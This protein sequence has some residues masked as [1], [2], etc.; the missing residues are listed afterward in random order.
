MICQ[1]RKNHWELNNL[2][3]EFDKNIVSLKGGL[4]KK[5]GTYMAS[6]RLHR[7]VVT[8]ISFDVVKLDE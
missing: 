5:I 2:G 6:I 8:E 1:L 3:F 7:D 4:I